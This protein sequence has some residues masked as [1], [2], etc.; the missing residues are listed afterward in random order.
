[1]K[2]NDYVICIRRGG[3]AYTVYDLEGELE[4]N[5]HKHALQRYL[6]ALGTP[7]RIL[8]VVPVKGDRERVLKADVAVYRKASETTY[9]AFFDLHPKQFPYP[10]TN[11]LC[12]KQHARKSAPCENE[13]RGTA[14]QHQYTNYTSRGRQ[15]E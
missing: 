8:R 11:E 10:L 1:M 15:D 6:L 4:A 5:G 14:A 3:G 2:N 9:R 7:Y 12:G 13:K